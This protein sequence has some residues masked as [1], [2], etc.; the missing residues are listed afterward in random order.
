MMSEAQIGS[1]Q[2]DR[3]VESIL[4]GRRHRVEEAGDL[5]HEPVA[6]VDHVEGEQPAQDDR[7]D[8]RPPQEAEGRAHQ[9]A[10]ETRDA[11]AHERNPSE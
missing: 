5:R 2:L 4:V 7:A 9:E 11:A 3:T 1:I 10:D 8:D 6:V